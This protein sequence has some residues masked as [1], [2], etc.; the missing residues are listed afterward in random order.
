M[1]STFS[2]ISLFTTADAV[3]MIDSY[4]MLFA[5]IWCWAIILEKILAIKLLKRSNFAF[6][7]VFWS[8]G[9]LD[10]LY[11]GIDKY[12]AAPKA[13]IFKAAMDEW[14]KSADILS[15]KKLSEM[16]GLSLQ[17]RIER[18]MQSAIDNE[19][20]KMGKRM[21]FLSTTAAIAPF[22]GLF[23]TVWGVME[24]F[25]ALGLAQNASIAVVGPGVAKALGTTALGLIAAIPAAV[26][27]N[28][29]VEDIEA[30]ENSLNAFA[31]D[32]MSIISRQLDGRAE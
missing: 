1:D 31:I 25:A 28:K 12:R 24:S 13:I 5:S 8:G 30:E 20:E 27:H 6:E 3:T 22:L 4:L 23:G 19:L 16:K 15:D 2:L 29:F 17:N 18:A 14:K 11:A 21:S 26:F 7:K 10:D 32:F 9:S